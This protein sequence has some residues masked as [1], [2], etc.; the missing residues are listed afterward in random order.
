METYPR[1]AARNAVRTYRTAAGG[2]GTR[3]GY[4]A[5]AGQSLRW[6]LVVLMLVAGGCASVK[7][8]TDWDAR[9]RHIRDITLI[10]PFVYLR[11]VGGPHYEN[12]VVIDPESSGKLAETVFKTQQS[13]L[14]RAYRLDV[15]NRLPDFVERDRHDSHVHRLAPDLVRFFHDIEHSGDITRVTPS[16][17]LV[18]GVLEMFP[19]EYHLLTYIRGFKR[20]DENMTATTVLGAVLS[21]LAMALGAYTVNLPDAAGYTLYVA[22]I[23]SPELD[24]VYYSKISTAK[25]EDALAEGV[26]RGRTRQVLEGLVAASE[27]RRAGTGG[28]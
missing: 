8:A 11:W 6:G 19:G 9:S 1:H 16:L 14:R 20:T 12:V 10:P 25:G 15:V 23:K 21:A 27:E 7:T 22:L 26:I 18:T 3:R 28:E 17:D 4:P 2:A 24:V 5:F 13:L